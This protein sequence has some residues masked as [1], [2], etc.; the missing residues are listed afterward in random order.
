MTA[1]GIA[2]SVQPASVAAGHRAGFG[3]LLLAEWTKIRSVRSTA[4][5]LVLFVIVTVGLTALLTWLI[6]SHWTGPNSG[7]R[8]ARI[9]TDPVGFIFGSGIGLGQ[10]TICVLG[11]LL[12]ST[13]YSTGV[14]R[15]SLL[16]VPRRYPMLAAKLVVFG[17]L[18][19][20]LSEVVAF[21]SFFVG[22]ALLH[23]KVAVSLSDT[24]MLRAT[25]GAGFYLTVLGI[26]ALAV[27]GIVR[28][29]AV[30]I[31]VTIGVV[32][33]LPI[34]SGLLPGSWG[35]HINAYL[36]QQAGSLVYS[37]HPDSALLSAWQ[38]FGVFCIWTV[39]LLAAAALLL[40]RR[41]A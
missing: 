35:A 37:V 10:L 30:G 2:S 21:G 17:V 1:T 31:S 5:T 4:W 24:G 3:H 39:L 19:L 33:I 14:I 9:V 12:M 11:V 41:D 34:I 32:L 40:D 38:G 7:T 23:S 6:E 22:S 13:E 25:L 8:D 18:I 15:A 16:A 20:V 27:G 29:T 36:P 28:L 26:F